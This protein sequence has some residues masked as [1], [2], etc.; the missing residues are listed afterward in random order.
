MANSNTVGLEEYW[1]DDPL[2]DDDPGPDTPVPIFSEPAP[3][4]MDLT[5]KRRICLNE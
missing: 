2:M 3:E 4:P 1:Y 5:G